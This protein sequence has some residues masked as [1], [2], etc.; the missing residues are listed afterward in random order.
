AFGVGLIV[1]SYTILTRE[2]ASTYAN[3]KPASALLF[4]QNIDDATVAAVC[5]L[6]GVAGAEARP[7]IRAR[8]GSGKGDWHPMTL[9]VVR[10]FDR[11]R[12]DAFTRNEGRWPPADDELLIERSS[13][14][15][16]RTAIGDRVVV[17]TADGA[18]HSLRVAGTV[19]APGLAPGWMDHHVSGFVTARSLVRADSTKELSRLMIVV[20]GNRLDELHIREIAARVRNLLERRGLKVVALDVP[21]PGRHP[22]ADQ[23]A[24]FLFLLGAFGALTLALS[25]VLVATMIHALLTEQ[26]R[27]VG[28]MKAIGATT[29]QIASLY[30]VQVSLLAAAALVLG[31]PLGFLAGRAYAGFAA[32]ILNATLSSNAV[33]AWAIAVQIAAGLLVP[34]AVAAGP[35]LRA[36]RIPIHQAFTNDVGRRPFGLRPFD[37]WLSR[38][39]WLPRPLML[40]LR[41]AFHR[42]G[43]L[44]LTVTTLAV[45]GAV[46]LTTLNVASAWRRTLDG[47]GRA[48]SYDL[49]VRLA[50]SRPVGEL[51]ATLATLPEVARAEYWSEGVA[52]LAAPV[53][54][55][56]R[57]HGIDDERVSVVHPQLPST[58]L[59][60]PL[61]QG[62]WLR[63]SDRDAAVI[64]QA[65]LAR[66]PSFRLGDPLRVRIDDRDVAWR[67]VGVVKE[68]APFPVAYAPQE[69]SMTA[70]RSLRVV[71]R[72]HDPASLRAASRALERALPGVTSVQAQADMRQAFA[73]HLVII[74]TALTLAALL[75]VLVGA[76]ALTSTMTLSVVER[77]RELGVLRAI[78]ATPRTLARDIVLEGTLIGALSWGV[79]LAAAVPLT[80]VLN[81]VSG[82]MFI[83]SGLDFVM[84]PGA[85]ALW[86]ALVLIVGALASFYPAWRASRLTVREALAYE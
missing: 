85:A 31:M 25:A 81:A 4:A 9:F 23:M 26:V 38:R 83:R 12:I 77:T 70:S 52:M 71:T 33:P 66:L 13:M 48:R 8:I 17:R 11:Q 37:R 61:L 39:A 78:G 20:T 57:L 22:H 19:H 7:T 32:G 29:R 27:Q 62:R 51:A 14:S 45:G 21:P 40:S 65:L 24:T 86:L 35:V 63:A 30:L 59:A 84:S 49:D 41:T 73:D 42:R 47:E 64:N 79:A 67:V 55:G 34:L 68:L 53:R 15:V 80:L 28:M 1:T 10:D 76:L 16:A 46:F 18:E 44:A 5:A 6:P 50:S 74:N 3:T 56:I 60:L 54:T 72:S 82:R 58:V 43:R 36:S 69:P 75:V 2:L